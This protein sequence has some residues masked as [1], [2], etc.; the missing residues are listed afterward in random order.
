VKPHPS[1][2]AATYS[3]SEHVFIAPPG[4]E[5][6]S[7]LAGAAGMVAAGG[8]TAVIDSLSLGT[9]TVLVQLDGKEPLLPARTL[10]VT[11]ARGARELAA[12]LDGEVP[13]GGGA[14]DLARNTGS[15]ARVAALVERLALGR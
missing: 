12:W 6:D 7:L 4:A 9:R 8:T 11:V 10:G 1:E 2:P 15:A 14:G 5:L 3:A 13:T